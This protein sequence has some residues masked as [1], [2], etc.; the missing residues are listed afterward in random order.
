MTDFSL[1]I[2]VSQQNG[3]PVVPSA[4]GWRGS[5]PDHLEGPPTSRTSWRR[6]LAGLTAAVALALPLGLSAPLATPAVAADAAPLKVALTSDIDTLN[7]FLAILASSTGILRF[8]Y[9]SLVQYGTNNELVPGLADKWTTSPDGKTWTFNIPAD[10]KWSDGKPLTAEDAVWTFDAVKTK[11]ALQQANGGLVTN[12]ASVSAKDPQT[13]VIT[14]NTA[15]AANPG[16]ELPIVPEHVWSGVDAATYAND[17][18]TVGSGPFVITSYAKSQSVQL[19]ANANFWRGTPS[20]G[21]LTYVSYKST[22]A[23]VQAL[24]TGEVDVVSGLTPA[25]FGSLKGQQG[26]TTNS[27]AGRRYQAIAINPGAVDAKG[28]PLGNGNPALKDQKLREAIFTAIDNQTLLDKVLQGLGKLGQTEVPT[29]YPDYFGFAPGTTARKFDPAAANTLLDEAGYPKGAD[30]IRT[31]KQGKPLKLRLMGRNTD[32]THQQMA[33]YVKP[34]LKAV[35]IDVTVSMV[36]PNQVNDD[37]TLGKYDLYFTGWGIGPDPDFQLSIN[38][39]DSRPN[40]DGSG[41]T[42]ESNWC[43]PAFDKL[44]DAQHAELDH[45]KR[46]ALVKQAFTMINNAAVNDVIYYADSLEAYRSDK[47]TG[48]TK[49]PEQGGVITGQNGYWGFYTAATAQAD[50]VG[51]NPRGG[52]PTWLIPSGVGAL[53]VIAVAVFAIRRRRTAADRE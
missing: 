12:V 44:Y 16:S 51:G 1:R 38:R 30:G 21:G 5:M 23:A 39:C 6:R 27:G 18:D 29:V 3:D 41:S 43:D 7:P 36:T 2:R 28:Q 8:Q 46:A 4:P 25:Q 10:R 42:S 33:D 22:D 11:E 47:F 53:V 17:K 45:T 32:P 34:W 19:K 26:I 48:F 37:S 24:R 52:L 31:D 20:V 9:E 14:L 49:Q 15:Q 35:G 13:L 50:T 40:A